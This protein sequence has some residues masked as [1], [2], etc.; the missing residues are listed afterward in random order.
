[1]QHYNPIMLLPPMPDK[2]SSLNPTVTSVPPLMHVVS[3]LRFSSLTSSVP[4]GFVRLVNVVDGQTKLLL[5]LLLYF[6]P[7]PCNYVSCFKG[8]VASEGSHMII[9]TSITY[10]WNIWVTGG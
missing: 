7:S 9:S 8:L 2:P 10:D 1:M 4:L 6:T 3:E 5:S